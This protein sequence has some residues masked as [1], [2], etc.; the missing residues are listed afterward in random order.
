MAS[1]LTFCGDCMDLM[2][3][4]DDNTFSLL[5]ADPPY[6]DGPQRLG[7]YGRPW[8]TIGVNRVNYKNDKGCWSLPTLEWFEESKRIS[9]DQV[10]WGANYFDF[11]GDSFP[12]PRRDGLDQFLL[13]HPVGW[14]VWDKCNGSSTFNDFEL[15]WTSYDRPTIVF[16]FMWNGM[17]QGKSISEG[18]VMQGNKR[19][20]EHRIHM[21]QKPVLLYGWLFRD[22]CGSLDSIFETH[23]G[24]GSARLAAYHLGIRFYGCDMDRKIFSLQEER[25]AIET[26]NLFK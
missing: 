3:L 15:A 19:L 6:F 20:N 5:S 23:L 25:F 8:S 14:I 9:I 2:P 11:I 13:D 10:I 18:G 4:Y 12:T 1:S 17:M 7:Y 21:T 26:F 24:S 22:Y 16:K